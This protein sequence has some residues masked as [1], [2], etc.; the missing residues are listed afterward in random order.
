MTRGLY[1]IAH[2]LP[3]RRDG[4]SAFRQLVKML[5]NGEMFGGENERISSVSGDET[6][7]PRPA[8]SDEYVQHIKDGIIGVSLLAIVLIILILV[9]MRRPG[10]R[11]GGSPANQSSRPQ[12]VQTRNTIIDLEGKTRVGSLDLGS[13]SSYV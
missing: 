10:E 4:D 12:S 6:L 13:S 3:Y 7:E 9:M 1:G 8:T 5:H 2:D 11:G